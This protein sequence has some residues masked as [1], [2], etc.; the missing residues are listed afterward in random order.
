[1]AVV[2]PSVLGMLVHA[3]LRPAR[4]ARALPF[5]KLA[6]TVTLIVLN[7]INA[8]AALPGVLRRPDAD[9]LALV[10]G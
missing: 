2:V 7:Y 5:V 10:F 3:L 8:A 1:L 9:Y 6:N 4:V